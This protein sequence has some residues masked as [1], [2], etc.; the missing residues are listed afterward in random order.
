[1]PML[2]YSFLYLTVL[3]FGSIMIVYLRYCGMTDHSIG[4]HSGISAMA[5]FVGS[6]FYPY[7]TNSLGIWTTGLYAILAQFTLVFSAAYAFIWVNNST[8]MYIFI[9]CIIFSRVGLWIFDLSVNQL[10]QEK[11][12]EHI[13]G[14]VNGVWRSF[15]AFFDASSF[16]CTIMFGDPT[17][18]FIL[19]MISVTMVCM[20]TITFV[21]AYC[22][23]HFD[24]F[25]CLNSICNLGSNGRNRRN[26]KDEYELIETTEDNTSNKSDTKFVC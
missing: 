24:I 15:Y 25:T 1:M 14:R 10:V 11:V 8:G 21:T 6:S 23:E 3:S 13:R 26:R 7:F 16:V 20:A 22:I 5:G 9:W 4:I 18:F 2:A 19:A 12:P 17:Q